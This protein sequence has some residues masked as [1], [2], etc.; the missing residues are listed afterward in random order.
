MKLSHPRVYDYTLGVGTMDPGRVESVDDPFTSIG[1]GLLY[2]LGKKAIGYGVERLAAR[3]AVKEGYVNLAS[4]A[5]TAHILAGDATGGGHSWF[6]SMKS[7]KNGIT[8]QKSMFPIRWSE[9][10]TMNAISEVATNNPWIQQ[11]G[12]AGSMF[13]KSGAA[14]RFVTE[15]VYD[16]VKMRVVV[17]HADIITAFPIK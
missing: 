7:F 10:K 6:S 1:P 17:T 3:A 9:S 11:T 2:G 14:S 8:G 5:R 15:G 13:T 16:G 12:K 4:E